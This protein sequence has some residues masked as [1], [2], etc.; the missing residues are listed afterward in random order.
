MM[1]NHLEMLVEYGHACEDVAYAR[2]RHHS[3]PDHWPVY[4]QAIVRKT[5]A[6][7]ALNEMIEKLES[8]AKA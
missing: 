8:G 4:E 3:D 7:S 1:K 5:H 2:E 6:K